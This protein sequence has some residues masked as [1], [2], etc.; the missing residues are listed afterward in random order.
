MCGGGGGGERGIDQMESHL[1]QGQV[2]EK[3]MGTYS[4]SKFTQITF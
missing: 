1:I 2:I 3:V 4:P